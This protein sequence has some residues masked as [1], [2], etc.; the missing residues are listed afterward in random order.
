MRGNGDCLNVIASVLPVPIAVRRVDVRHGD[1][2]MVSVV[3]SDGINLE[4]GLAVVQRD[5][6]ENGHNLKFQRCIV[7]LNVGWEPLG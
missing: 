6:F 3:R 4:A 7:L 5:V 2:N 1:S